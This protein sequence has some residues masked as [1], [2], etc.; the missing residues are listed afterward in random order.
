MSDI[1]TPYTYF[2]YHKPTGLK[3]YGSKTASKNKNKNL[4]ANPDLFWKEYFSSSKDV[5]SL[6]EN[7]GSDS[8]LAIVHKT[9]N[10]AQEAIL[11]EEKVLRY[12]NVLKR[13][14]WINKNISGKLFLKERTKEWIDNMKKS[15]KG[16]SKTKTFKFLNRKRKMYKIQLPDSTIITINDLPQ[17]CLEHNLSISCMR[18]NYRGTQGPHRGFVL[19]DIFSPST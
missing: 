11:Y 8:F 1:Y 13:K 19:L 16:K 10:T 18:D 12:F 17:F 14:D 3:Y 7:Y 2:L 15:L 9:F 6:I 5:K 4:N